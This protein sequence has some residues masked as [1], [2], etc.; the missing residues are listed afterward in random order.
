[1]TGKQPTRAKQDRP[2][3]DKS[4]STRAYS[5]STRAAGEGPR[6]ARA[7]TTASD[8]TASA[9]TATR[10]LHPPHLRPTTSPT[11]T[12][13]PTHT[14][15]ERQ[16]KMKRARFKYTSDRDSKRE[17]NERGGGREEKVREG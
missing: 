12:Y 2:A 11:F 6:R 4:Q 3:T 1:M 17:E 8:K 10:R 5:Q 15:K 7:H 14:E 9:N 13:Q 16:E